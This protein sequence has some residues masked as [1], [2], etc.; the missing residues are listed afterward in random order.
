MLKAR[1]IRE[2]TG[3]SVETVAAHVEIKF[4][5]LARFERGQ[6]GLGTE[7]LKRLA[8]YYTKALHRPITMDEL[9]TVAEERLL[10]MDEPVR[11]PFM[12]PA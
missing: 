12:E 2:E 5:H 10:E 9:T 7:K 6:V 8:G 4:S 11:E 3:Q 1:T